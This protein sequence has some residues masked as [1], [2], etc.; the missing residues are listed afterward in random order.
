MDPGLELGGPILKS[1][2]EE[3]PSFETHHYSW[4]WHEWVVMELLERLA[5]YFCLKR[6]KIV[7]VL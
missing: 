6:N 2:L 4:K 5:F 1:S 3:L 7:L